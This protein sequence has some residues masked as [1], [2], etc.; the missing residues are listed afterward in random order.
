MGFTNPLGRQRSAACGRS[1]GTEA[2]APRYV[3]VRAN[4]P[5]SAGCSFQPGASAPGN[6]PGGLGCNKGVG[7]STTLIRTTPICLPRLT[8][9]KTSRTWERDARVYWNRPVEKRRMCTCT[10]LRRHRVGVARVC[11]SK[12]L[13]VALAPTPSRSGFATVNPYRC[14]SRLRAPAPPRLRAFAP[15]RPLTSHV[16]RLALACSPRMKR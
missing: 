13:Q 12:P 16:S 6:R 11:D 2:P 15:S 9:G 10:S 4:Q 5:A 7:E 14:P 1:R 3:S 8:G